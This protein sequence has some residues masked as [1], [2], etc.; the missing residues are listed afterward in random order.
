MVNGDLVLQKMMP[1]MKDLANSKL[2]LSW[3]GPYKVNDSK[4][5]GTY[6][7]ETLKGNH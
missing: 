5:S 3:E 1:L 6:H 2:G 4:R 7:L